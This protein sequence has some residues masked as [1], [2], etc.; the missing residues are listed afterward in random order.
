MLPKADDTWTL[1]E[2][3]HLLNRA[4][5]GGSPDE[6]K[7]IHAKGR[8]KAV[9]LLLGTNAGPDPFP[10]PEWATEERMLE[11]EIT[12]FMKLVHESRSQARI[13]HMLATGKPLR[14]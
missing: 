4:G 5:F 7:A 1:F 12:E 2:A 9:D 6:I 10:L 3:A 13:E 14:N 8:T 11:L